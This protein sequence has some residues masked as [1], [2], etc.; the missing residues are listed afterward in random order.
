MAGTTQEL[1][2]RTECLTGFEGRELDGQVEI[3]LHGRPVLSYS[4]SDAVGRD[5][6]I[7]TLLHIGLRGKSVAQLCAMSEAHVTGVRKR[8]AAGG[9][10]ALAWRGKRGP[11]KKLTGRKLTKLRKLNAQG[12]TLSAIGRALSVHHS[13][14]ACALAGLGVERGAPVEQ[15]TLPQV[16]GRGVAEALDEGAMRQE[17]TAPA[18]ESSPGAVAAREE[19]LSPG[20]EL[21][22]GPTEHPSR[23]AGTV[24]LAAAMA[25]LG[26]PCAL[27]EANVRRRD[28]AVYDA[29]QVVMALACAWVAGFE[30]L[31]SMHERDARGLGVVL[32]LERS[33]SVRTAHRAIGDM[34]EHFDPIA[35][36]TGLMRGLRAAGRDQPLLFGIDGHF[37]EYTGDAPIDKGWNAHKRMATKGLSVMLVH[38]TQGVTWLSFSVEAGDA[39]SQHVLTAARRLRHVHGTDERIVLGFDRGGFSFETLCALDREGF[40]YLA[41]VP[42]NA[43]KPPLADVAP[44]EDG[45]GEVVWEHER[46]DHGARLLVQR[47]GDALL[48]AVTNLEPG[49]EA[50]EAIRLLRLVRG[51]EENAI[52][53]ARA[54]THIDRLADRGVSREQPDDRLVNNPERAELREAKKKVEQCLAVLDEEERVAGRRSRALGEQRFLPELQEGIVAAKLRA[55]PAK[56]PRVA[57]EPGA[58]RAWLETK[59]RAL[60]LP[61]KLAADNARRWLLAALSVALAPTDHGYDA[62]AMPRTLMALLRAPG[63]VRFGRDRVVVTLDF[64]LPPTAHARIDEALRSLDHQNLAFPDNRGLDRSP[65]RQVVFRLETRPTRA[66]LPHARASAAS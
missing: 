31:E 22:V 13:T 7:A 55:T 57:L 40:G 28:A 4:S 10:E 62:T 52:K 8:V 46:L 16:G 54:S 65:R 6:V 53:A 9:V 32:G 33:P 12:L 58:I 48:P 60:L 29:G 17:A 20:A 37:K 61:L 5:F 56:L 38:D 35:L 18:K 45:V 43:R 26:V 42:G 39:L 23:Y 34:V 21:P 30:S 49:L 47:D 1:F 15:A 50:A 36:G 11:R 14:V 27:D 2:T 66:T 44:A 19:A 24:L 59:N 51:V 64:P 3:L 41:W 25:K 63:T